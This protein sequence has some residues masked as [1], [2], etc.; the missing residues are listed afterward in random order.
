MAP[1]VGVSLIPL[2]VLALLLVLVI[3]AFGSDSILGGSQVAL[4]SA[5]SVCVMLSVG[6]YGVKWS[7]LENE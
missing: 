6:L 3:R 1:S 7:R 5:S 2:L 4:L